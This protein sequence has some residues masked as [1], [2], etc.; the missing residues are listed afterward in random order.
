MERPRDGYVLH[1]KDPSLKAND[2]DRYKQWNVDDLVMMKVTEHQLFHST[3]DYPFRQEN[4]MKCFILTRQ[5][6]G[7]ADPDDSFSIE[8]QEEECKKLALSKEIDVIDVFREANTSGRLYPK[9]YESIASQDFIYKRWCEE[10]K[11]V[12]LFREE[13]GEMLKRLDEVD[14]IVCYDIT[15]LFR[16]L[17]GSFLSNV[18]SQTLI[19]HKI[20]LITIKEGIVDFNKFQDSLISSLTS[21]IN[22]EQLAIQREKCIAALKKLK[23]DGAYHPGLSRMLGFMAT[24]RKHEVVQ[25]DREA[26]MVKD[27]YKHFNNGMTISKVTQYVNNQYADVFPRLSARQVI[28]K[29]LL[30]PIY[31]G[32]MYDSEGQLVKAKQ[33]DGKEIVTLDEWMKAKRKLDS[34]KMTASRQKKHWLPLSAFIYCGQCGYKMISHGGAGG[35]NQFYTCQRHLKDGKNACK[36]NITVSNDIKEGVGMIELIKPLLLAEAMKQ[37]K[38]SKED[39]KLK[40]KLSILSISI[41]EAKR[42]MKKLTE[43]WMSSLMTEE[44]YENAMKE[45]KVKTAEAEKEKIKIEALLSRDTS[46]FEWVKLMMKFKGDGL[47]HGEYEML[48]NAMLKKILVY[49]DF[50]EVKTTFGEVS[51][52][53]QHVGRYRLGCNY[54]IQMNKGKAAVYFYNGSAKAYPASFWNDAK[55][56]GVLG[57][58]DIFYKK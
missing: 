27:I 56:I 1:H 46:Q 16:P 22:S 12:G 41:E 18:I 15:R 34:R 36:N 38:M 11:K 32:Y 31:A 26:K 58:L 52:P 14:Y 9:G 24:G 20:K 7:Q 3:T 21:Q 2:P 29:I 23:N 37:M 28:R 43:M 54:I 57:E 49:R 40:E 25:N 53:R 13:L 10:V 45:I 35:R 44:I 39:G 55:K 8:V 33:V 30:S 19:E 48:A 4:K 6:S 17:N 51:L 42:K 50:I 5:S 47:T